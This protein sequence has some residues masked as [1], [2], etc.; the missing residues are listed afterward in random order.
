MVWWSNGTRYGNVFLWKTAII[1]KIVLKE[2]NMKNII[3]TMFALVAVVII[4]GCS[5]Q[6]TD[7]RDFLKGN[8]IIYTGAVGNVSNHPGKN[9]VE[10]KWKSSSDP[11]ITKYIVYWNNKLDSQ[12]VNIT[13][14]K[15]SVSA[16]IS[17]LQEYVY[18]FT[19]YSADAKGNR[20]IPQEINNVKIYGDLYSSTL[21]NRGYDAVQPYLTYTEDKVEL[22][23]I[24]PDTI[25]VS[26]TIKYEN[27]FGIQT[28]KVFKG[29][30]NVITL[31]DHKLNTPILYKSAYIPARGAI[32]T[33]YVSNFSTYPPYQFK[34]IVCNK[35]LFSA[36]SLARDVGV[37]EAGT[38]INKLW[39]GSTTPQSYPNIFHSS[40]KTLPHAITFDM[41]KVY[42]DLRRVE[43][44]GRDGNHNPT[45]FEIWGIETTPVE[46]SV[47]PSNAA[48]PAEAV[49]KG[50]KLLV[51][52]KRTDNGVNPM[53]FAFTANPSKIRY[54][55]VRIKKVASGSNDSSNMTQLTFWN[56][57]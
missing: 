14:K 8:E 27:K 19:I 1:S 44:I 5:K 35:S 40:S 21:L 31:T 55:R 7:F 28:E 2:K 12:V 45:E 46:L 41:G 36:L 25:H 34:E 18:A 54:I 9:R 13:Q 52:A 39:N 6:D 4:Y 49:S 56:Y 15:D 23:F 57:Q 10:L 3:I 32:D 42:N 33:F 11:T 43:I 37:Y 47:D 48:W 29:N 22:N 20:S 51:D 24:T 26:T 50:W 17:G 38:G 53:K 30:A 16:V